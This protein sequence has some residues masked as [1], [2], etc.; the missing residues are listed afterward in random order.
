MT[1][2]TFGQ[3]AEMT[4]ADRLTVADADSTDVLV[5]ALKKTYP[6]LESM[7]FLL[8]VDQVV[9]TDNT[10]LNPNSVVALMPPFSG[11]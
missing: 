4:G 1:I 8:A 9:V 10:P 3:I 2:L 7:D 5:E 6:G 11:G